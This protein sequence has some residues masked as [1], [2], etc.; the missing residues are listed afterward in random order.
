MSTI[1][2][3]GWRVEDEGHCACLRVVVA[4][5]SSS[6]VVAVVE[7]GGQETARSRRRCRQTPFPPLVDSTR[8]RVRQRGGGDRGWACDLASTELQAVAGESGV[9]AS[10]RLCARGM[11]SSSACVYL[12]SLSLSLSL[13][14]SFTHTHTRAHTH[15][16]STRSLHFDPPVSA[17]HPVRELRL[18]E[19][20]CSS[21]VV[22]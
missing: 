7:Y 18:H 8:T 6:A 11:L 12:S 22:T 5:L 19:P 20:A 16:L 15:A 13:S 9:P 21:A 17:R 14:L 3:L 10:A 1:A 4:E 2:S